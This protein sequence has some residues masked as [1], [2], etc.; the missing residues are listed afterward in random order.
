MDIVDEQGK[1]PDFVFASYLGLI[2]TGTSMTRL[3]RIVFLT[4]P[5]GTDKKTETETEV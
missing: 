5:E 1:K 2:T 3:M 4:D